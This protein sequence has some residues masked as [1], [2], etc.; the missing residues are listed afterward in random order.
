[1]GL[2]SDIALVAKSHT[3]YDVGLMQAR[4]YR[5]LKQMT[6]LVLKPEGLTTVEWAILG[7]LSHHAKGLRA[8]EIADAL[9]VQPPLVSRLLVRAESD[10]WITIEQGEEDKRERVI[11]LSEK[12]K[13]GV[14]RIEKNVRK[15]LLP[16]LKGVGAKDLAGYLRT[17]ATIAENGKD[18]PAGSLDDY[19]PE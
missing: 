16:L 14:F 5:T 9:G 11:R 1:M 13:K 15:G 4:G 18:L 6:A 12:G 3:T 19:I 10:H 7:I 17:L 8:S 2:F